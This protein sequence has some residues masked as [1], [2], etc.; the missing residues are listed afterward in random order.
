MTFS[1]KIKVDKCV[2][3][4]NEVEN[5]YYKTFVPDVVKNIS[6]KSFDLI[7]QKNVLKKYFISSKL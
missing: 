1:N 5:P 3:S 4:C 7:S 6:V 2:R